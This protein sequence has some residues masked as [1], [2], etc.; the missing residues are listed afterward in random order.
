MTSR[1]RGECGWQLSIFSAHCA[2][3]FSLSSNPRTLSTPSN[4]LPPPTQIQPSPSLSSSN[5]LY[6]WPLVLTKLC[7]HCDLFDFKASLVQPLSTNRQQV[8]EDATSL[9]VGGCEGWGVWLGV[10]EVCV[11][12]G[13]M[14][15]GGW[16]QAT[17][18]T[19]MEGGCDTQPGIE[20]IERAR[21]GEKQ[22]HETLAHHHTHT[23]QHICTQTHTNVHTHGYT[24]V[25][26]RPVPA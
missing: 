5:P 24:P 6:L 16:G 15:L 25:L 3:L 10:F 21:G 12:L 26:L 2:L 4:P 20:R 14:S 22:G 13:W 8:A 17:Y 7:V 19:Q 9:C 1:W 11:V 23:T 18:Q